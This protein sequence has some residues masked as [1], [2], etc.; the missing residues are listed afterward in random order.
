MTVGSRGRTEFP[1]RTEGKRY[2]WR[3]G[4][5]AISSLPEKYKSRT[6]K[7]LPLASP[8]PRFRIPPLDYLYIQ[9]ASHNHSTIFLYRT[10]FF[11]LVCM[12]PN[13][14]KKSSICDFLYLTTHKATIPLYYHLDN[15]LYFMYYKAREWL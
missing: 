12:L 11:Y 1:P 3:I 8:V 10:G 14:N 7:I 2:L 4:S 5:S 15:F 9:V 13:S 6:T